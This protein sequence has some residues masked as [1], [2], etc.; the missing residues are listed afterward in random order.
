MLASASTGDAAEQ[1]DALREFLP[2]HVRPGI[3]VDAL[4]AVL[5]QAAATAAPKTATATLA[6]A[7]AAAAPAQAAAAAPK[8]AGRTQY[9]RLVRADLD[10]WAAG[11]DGDV[12]D[13]GDSAFAVPAGAPVCRHYLAG[14]CRRA[15]CP[16]SHAVADTVCRFWLRGHCAKGDACEFRHASA[17]PAAPTPG[18]S[19]TDALDALDALD[20]QDALDADPAAAVPLDDDTAF[21]PLSEEAARAPVAP[22][23]YTLVGR[24]SRLRDDFSWVPPQFL[25]DALLRTDGDVEAAAASLRSSFPR[26]ATLPTPTVAAPAVGGSPRA[27]PS[28]RP[29]PA[30]QRYLRG[31]TAPHPS[32]WVDTGVSVSK[33]YSRLRQEATQHAA[34]RNAFFE[35]AQTAY[36]RGDGA[37]ARALSRQG[38]WH[39]DRMQ[40][41]HAGAAWRARPT[42]LARAN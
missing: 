15:D 25:R 24:V 8:A 16:F 35:A 40:E 20:A 12:D 11:D 14:E 30:G 10:A 2:E 13:G 5:V 39:H 19:W 17:A 21:P 4:V 3:D 9:R 31:G 7:A 29:A 42:G 32:L 41:L 27:A 33:Q 28:S 22:L 6:S 23:P 26:P 37:A 36:R 34:Q 1:A 18:D 38:R